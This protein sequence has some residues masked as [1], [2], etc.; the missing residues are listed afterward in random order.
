MEVK[1][2]TNTKCLYCTK[3]LN[4]MVQQPIESVDALLKNH[5]RCVVLEE[6]V[7]FPVEMDLTI[8]ELISFK[9][10]RNCIFRSCD[11]DL[12]ISRIKNENNT[13]SFKVFV[14]IYEAID[15]IYQ[16]TQP[17]MRKEIPSIITS[18]EKVIN[19]F[20]R[21]IIPK[22]EDFD[23]TGLDQNIGFD[24]EDFARE[25]E[26]EN[27]LGCLSKCLH[28]NYLESILTCQNSEK[29][30]NSE[31]MKALISEHP[32]LILSERL[33][34]TVS[35][36]LIPYE[37][38]NTPD[39]NE[40]NDDLLIFLSQKETNIMDIHLFDDKEDYRVYQIDV[41]HNPESQF[42][43]TTHEKTLEFAMSKI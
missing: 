39:A 12:N 17:I 27:I 28:T 22:G 11:N 25:M 37:L 8:K 15:T 14:S 10:V 3:D 1:R 36:L 2:L 41:Y 29:D 21:L 19:E 4:R 13:W 18:I 7:L 43:K 20:M 35:R 38:L 9:Y 5:E 30:N 40:K 33:A 6:K 32:D 16:L 31:I 26:K 34:P 42:I 24:S 23:T